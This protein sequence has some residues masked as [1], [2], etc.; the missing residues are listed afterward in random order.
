MRALSQFY[1]FIE[2]EVMGCPYVVIDH[3]LRQ[4]LREF[5]DRTGVWQEW[6]DALT[7]DGTTLT[8]DADLS[9]GQELVNV[10]RATLN[11]VDIDVL[12]GSGLPGDWDQAA[13]AKLTKNTLV[14]FD[15]AQF[16]VFPTPTAGDVLRVL[17]ALQ[18][19]LAATQVG[20]VLLNRWADEVATG[21][22]ARLMAMLGQSWS[23][24]TLAAKY[25]SE[26]DRKCRDAANNDFARGKQSRRMKSCP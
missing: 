18:P 13:P 7:L 14:H 22:K 24:P 25:E 15:S 20:D 21:C 12:A 6:A 4:A 8:F 19:S 9:S 5:C 26:F 17:Q 11:G 10:V 16:M 2:P 23:N 1:P 3:H